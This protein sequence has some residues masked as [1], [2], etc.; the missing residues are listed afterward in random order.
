METKAILLFGSNIMWDV[1]HKNIQKHFSN[2]DIYAL[3]DEKP[4]E[5]FSVTKWEKLS[6]VVKDY[7]YENPNAIK[8][9]I[10]ECSDKLKNMV[11]I[12]EKNYQICVY[13][14]ANTLYFSNNCIDSCR[15][16]SDDHVKISGKNLAIKE[17]SLPF[18]KKLFSSL[19]D[20]VYDYENLDFSIDEKRPLILISSVIHINPNFSKRSVYTSQERF[21][22]TVKQLESIKEKIPN[23]QVF[24]LECSELTFREM[25][26]FSKLA[27]KVILF[28]KDSTV[29]YHA[30]EDANKNNTEIHL[31]L[32]IIDM[33]RFHNKYSTHIAKISG[34]YSINDNFDEKKFFSDKSVFRV[35]PKTWN[36]KKAIESIFFCVEKGYIHKFTMM[37]EETLYA[38]RTY[39]LDIEHGLYERIF[40]NNF[41][42][43]TVDVLGVEGYMAEGIYN[44][45]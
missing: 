22:Q 1:I 4:P 45:V 36:N 17:L 27:N 3:T 5:Y 12:S 30:H 14:F 24:L 23:A 21:E 42:I 18:R 43:N 33:M 7:S 34:R 37:L 13:Y 38:I 8:A 10:Q 29:Y 16:V 31:F 19:Y 20:N 15:I 40:F 44:S 6:F 2:S 25:E 26:K 32:K 9:Y 41:P 39:Y 28:S 35:V 11:E